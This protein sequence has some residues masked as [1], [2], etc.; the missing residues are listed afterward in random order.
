VQALVA[1][2]LRALG[3]LNGHGGAEIAA[4]LPPKMGG[5]DRAAFVWLLDEDRQMFATDGRMPEAAARREW[6]VMS[7]LTPKYGK[8]RFEQTF[9]NAFVDKAL[10][11]KP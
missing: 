2:C 9:T 5:K 6:Q 10:G 11:A 3:W 1:A 7:Q 4:V 8:I